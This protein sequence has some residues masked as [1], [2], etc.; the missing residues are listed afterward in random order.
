M[1]TIAPYKVDF[2]FNG[3]NWLET[4]LK[5]RGIA[6]QKDDNAFTHIADFAEAQ[7]LSDRLRVEDL[8]S[9]LDILIKRYCPMPT[10]W[11]QSFNYTIMQAEYALDIIFKSVEDLKPLYDNINEAPRP[12]GRGI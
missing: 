9:A 2:Y 4:K 12:E 10:G 7:K 6:Y 3:H 8:H 5:N 1:P 11:E